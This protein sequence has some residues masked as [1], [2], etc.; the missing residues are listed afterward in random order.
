MNSC[1]KTHF[2]VSVTHISL[3]DELSSMQHTE[4][5]SSDVILNL[6]QQNVNVLCFSSVCRLEDHPPFKV[7]AQM[8]LSWR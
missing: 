3:A 7:K 4:H 8:C 6:K 1:V 2:P 5:V